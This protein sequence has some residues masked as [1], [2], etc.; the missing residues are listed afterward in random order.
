MN[1]KKTRVE[2]S[3]ELSLASQIGIEKNYVYCFLPENTIHVTVKAY[4]KF[5][6]LAVYVPF[7][8]ICPLLNE[9]MEIQ[10]F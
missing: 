3:T 5:N 8:W 6:K 9:I 2:I 1:I 7:K 4:N 10:I